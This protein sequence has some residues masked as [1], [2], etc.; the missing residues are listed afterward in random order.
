MWSWI[1]IDTRGKAVSFLLASGLVGVL[2][3]LTS[4]GEVWRLYGHLGNGALRSDRI[5]VLHDIAAV[6]EKAPPDVLLLG[7]SQLRELMPEDAFVS[8]TLSADCGRTIRV[9]NAA[10]SSQLLESSW[11]LA[12]L[13]QRPGQLV[14]VNL[15][16]WRVIETQN[17]DRLPRTLMPLPVADSMPPGFV[18]A[19]LSPFSERRNRL[20]ILFTDA[21]TASGLRGASFERLGP[22]ATT[23]HA[24]RDL[25]QSADQKMFDARFQAARLGP[26]AE[27]GIER[28]ASGF[29]ALARQLSS[30][31]RKVAFLLT[32]SSPEV[33]ENLERLRE[34]ANRATAML[35]DAAPLLDLREVRSL[36]DADF[37]DNLHLTTQGR[38]RLWPEL[39]SFLHSR[40]PGC[41]VRSAP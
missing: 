29:A 11:A 38:M 10:T 6:W 31:G 12:D 2:A 26:L 41:G 23:Q 15:N 40:V 3:L 19:P 13:L 37:A 32:P 33:R 1:L 14:I 27:R 5:R 4:G 25:P 17:F 18:Q 7:G 34:P 22:F 35:S 16:I 24:Y 39:R 28:N 9:F 8:A 36:D 20:G 30:E 21:V